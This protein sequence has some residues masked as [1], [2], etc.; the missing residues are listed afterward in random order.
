MLDGYA[1]IYPPQALAEGLTGLAAV[2]FTVDEEG[3][4]TRLR[5][6]SATNPEFGDAVLTAVERWWFRPATLQGEPVRMTMRVPFPFELPDPPGPGESLA[7]AVIIQATETL[8]GIRAEHAWL[9]RHLPGAEVTRQRLLQGQGPRVYDQI[10]VELP[11]GD[12]RVVY[13]DIT[14]F[15]GSGLEGASP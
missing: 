10:E 13:F 5:V 1:P 2:V 6:E 4:P 3:R 15:F 8:E 14:S 9:R 11:S 12:R 7:T